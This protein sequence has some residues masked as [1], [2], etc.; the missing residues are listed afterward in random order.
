MAY[1]EFA[2][3]DCIVGYEIWGV[4]AICDGDTLCVYGADEE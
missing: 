3:H 4:A 2:L 1:E